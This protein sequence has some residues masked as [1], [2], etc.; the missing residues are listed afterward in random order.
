MRSSQYHSITQM[1]TGALQ[2][3]DSVKMHEYGNT[4]LSVDVIF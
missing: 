4:A 2:V 3:R 1:T